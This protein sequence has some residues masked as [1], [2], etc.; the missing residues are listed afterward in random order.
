MHG[1]AWTPKDSRTVAGA[2]RKTE[3]PFPEMEKPGRWVWGSSGTQPCF[4]GF[5]DVLWTGGVEQVDMSLESKKAQRQE[6][7]CWSEQT[8]EPRVWTDVRMPC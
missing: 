6:L 3:P 8:G 7:G 1:R 2:A 5:E 4:H